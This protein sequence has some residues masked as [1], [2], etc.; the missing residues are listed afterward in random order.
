MD[1]EQLSEL[2]FASET[3]QKN[4]EEFK[5][6]GDFSQM[7]QKLSHLE[8]LTDD[9]LKQKIEKIDFK[10][11][12]EKAFA[13]G[14]RAFLESTNK[15]IESQKAFEK[16]Q[17]KS[18]ESIKLV[19]LKVLHE[20]ADN[21]QKILEQHKKIRNK[22]VFFLGLLMFFINFCL[23]YVLMNQNIIEKY[24]PSMSKQ[25]EYREDTTKIDQ[26]KDEIYDLKYKNKTQS[27][28]INDLVAENKKLKKEIKE[29]EQT[30]YLNIGGFKIASAKSNVFTKPDQNSFS[31][32]SLK[33][34]ETVEIES[35]DENGWCK[36]QDKS[37]YIKKSEI[38]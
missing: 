32:Y 29:K 35:C 16:A 14:E 7:T 15:L 30:V 3:L 24:I 1:K 4:L 31:P 22:S 9:F 27:D 5:K 38:K 28:S 10:K 36:L 18:E 23:F 37:L 8:F 26:M 19:D 11:M 2:V 21:T 13:E 25:V 20:A 33:K 34:N 6:M 17:Q 12:S